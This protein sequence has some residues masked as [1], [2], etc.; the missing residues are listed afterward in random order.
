MPRS[1]RSR[2]TVATI[3]LQSV[4]MITGRDR[5]DRRYSEIHSSATDWRLLLGTGGMLAALY[6]CARLF[7][8]RARAGW[9]KKAGS[10]KPPKVLSQLTNTL[11][12]ATRL[13]DLVKRDNFAS[14]NNK[15]T[16]LCRALQSSLPD[17]HTARV[18]TLAAD[19]C[20][21]LRRRPVHASHPG[22]NAFRF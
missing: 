12:S 19:G 20:R 14:R 10:L 16:R 4:G 7:L 17:A 21:Y 8:P 15:A 18:D 2:M 11:V 1:L 22:R 3:A 6:M 13:E 5:R 9:R